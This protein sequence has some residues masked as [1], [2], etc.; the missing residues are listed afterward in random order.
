MP[1]V[2]LLLIEAGISPEVPASQKRLQAD[3]FLAG[4]SFARLDGDLSAEALSRA[5]P[6]II[7]VEHF[8]DRSRTLQTV[9][10]VRSLCAHIP[11]V[12]LAWESSEEFAIDALNAG[13]TRYLKL[14][15]PATHLEALLLA[16]SIV[17]HNQAV[18][19]SRELQGESCMVGNSAPMC[20]LRRYIQQV[21]ISDSNVL[22]TGETGTGKELVAQLIQENSGRRDRP[23]I[24]LNSAAIPEALVE[25]ELF[26]YEKGAF[27][28]ALSAQDGKLAAANH[29]TV[30]FDEIGDVS[31]IV[32]AKLLRAI[33]S[34]KIYR[35]GSNRSRDLD[36]RILAA[37]NQDL[38]TATLQNRFRGDLY[39]RL[40]VVRIE[41]PPLRERLDDLPL[42]VEYYVRHFSRAFQKRVNGCSNAVMDLLFSYSWPGNIRE[43]KNVLEAAFVTFSDQPDGLLQLTGPLARSL[44]AA[45]KLD[46]GERTMLLQALTAT[47]WNRTEAAKRLH[48]SRMTLYRKMIRYQVSPSVKP[49]NR[50]QTN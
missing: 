43:L 46:I 16:L 22:I 32:Q 24:C 33:E 36:I 47:N 14:P 26:G 31:P 4:F 29:G 17:L 7:L 3:D 5:L 15:C 23:Y 10:S 45:A 20:E 11:I 8:S 34:K 50:F 48:W 44:S 38:E 25:S 37:S 41:V 19:L 2:R 35:L 12:L 1:L 39:Y 9:A 40:N 42:L 30:F 27:T 28:G 18:P 49:R 13:V 6:E 21:A